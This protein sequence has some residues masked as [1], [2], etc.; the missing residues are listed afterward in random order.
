MTTEPAPPRRRRWLRRPPAWTLLVIAAVVAAGVAVGVVIIIEQGRAV[1]ENRDAIAQP[2]AQQAET[3][4]TLC[5]QGGAVAEALD[6]AGQCKLAGQV[7]AEIES[8]GVPT[9]VLAVPEL[10]ED[11]L[12]SFVRSA[13][14]DYCAARA[15]CAPDTAVLVRIVADFLRANPPQPGRAPTPEEIGAAARTVI[16]ADPELFRGEPGQDATDD[17]VAATVAAYCA[18]RN[19]C[20]GPT[21]EK[22][23]SIQGPQ[24]VGVVDLQFVRNEAGQ[25]EAVVTYLDPKDGS[26]RETRRATGSAACEDVPPPPAETTTTAEPP[27]LLGEN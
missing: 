14:T 25:C 27:P 22:G 2:A 3:V 10:D 18:Q 13:V 23:E 21:G 24:G 5:A 4:E 11:Q 6:A 1:T 26:Q 20:R 15:S 12:M 19:E 16:L 17:Q 7:K 8:A 9:T